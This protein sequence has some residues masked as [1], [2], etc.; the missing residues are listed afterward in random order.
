L[1]NVFPTAQ[2]QA[3]LTALKDADAMLD[4]ALVK[5]Y[6]ND[7]NPG[8]TT[9]LGDFE[10]ATFTGYTTSSAIAWAGPVNGDDGEPELVGQ[11]LIFTATSGTPTNTI[12]GYYVID[13]GGALLYSERFSTQQQVSKA[14]DSVIFV[15]RVG[16]DFLN[17]ASE[18]S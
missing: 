14:G 17:G 3:A 6:Q 11:R 18:V 15:P 9:V 10:V 12:F 2:I 13:A 16:L 4:G 5:L 1:S 7:L 8:P